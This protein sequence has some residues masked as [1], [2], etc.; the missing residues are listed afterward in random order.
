MKLLSLFT[1]IAAIMGLFIAPSMIE[2]H[3]RPY[4]NSHYQAG[5]GNQY[6]S[7]IHLL[8]IM[9]LVDVICTDYLLII[10]EFLH[11]FLK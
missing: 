1:L 2:A 5:N 11:S 4:C 10:F 6:Q 9:V 3:R 8:V 7:G